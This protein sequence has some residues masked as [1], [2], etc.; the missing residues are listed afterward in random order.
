MDDDDD[1]GCGVV[2]LVVDL[3]SPAE[4]A[5]LAMCR[6]E[7]RAETWIQDSVYKRYSTQGYS[8]NSERTVRSSVR[9]LGC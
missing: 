2:G 7:A 6:E 5:R 1:D 3:V 4:A 8:S 9:G